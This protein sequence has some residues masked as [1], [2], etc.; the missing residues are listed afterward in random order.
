MDQEPRTISSTANCRKVGTINQ[1]KICEAVNCSSKASV[2]IQV[3]IGQ[4]GSISLSLCN[5]CVSKFRDE[6]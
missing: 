6:Q 1:W 4:L 2:Q 5:Y 3:K